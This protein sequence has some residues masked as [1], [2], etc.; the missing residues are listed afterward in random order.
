MA[1]PNSTVVVVAGETAAEVVPRLDV[2]ANV[3]AAA[4]PDDDAARELV[5]HS[6]AAYVVHDA[7]PLSGLAAAWAGFFDGA[8]TPGTLEVTVEAT[9]SRLRTGALT[10]PDYYVLLDPESLAA[11][12]RHWWL[13]VLAGV[14]PS[15]VIPAAPHAAAVAEVLSRLPSGR[16]WPDPPEEWLR[17]LPRTVPDSVALPQST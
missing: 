1:R 6:H 13:G 9:L 10:L 7:D 3:R 8:G 4:V 12:E 11:T 14:S 15:R 16:W 17:A 5:A 2:L